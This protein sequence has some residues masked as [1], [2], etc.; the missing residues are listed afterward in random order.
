MTRRNDK[1]SFLLKVE[2]ELNNIEVIH[3]LRYE[4]LTVESFGPMLIQ[5]ASGKGCVA[6]RTA[7]GGVARLR[8][9]HSAHLQ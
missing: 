3:K 6:L 4:I 1:V 8:G 5:D 7:L 9:K 2:K